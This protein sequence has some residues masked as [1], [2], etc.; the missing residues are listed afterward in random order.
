MKKRKKYRLNIQKSEDMGVFNISVVKNPAIEHDTIKLSKSNDFSLQIEVKLSAENKKHIMFGPILIPNKEILRKTEEGDIDLIFTNEDIEIIR[1]KFAKSNINSN[2]TLEHLGIKLNA[3]LVEHFIQ[4]DMIK[5][6]GFE[7]LK[8][9]WMGGVLI[10]DEDFWNNWV[11]TD[12]VKGFSIEIA[13]VLEEYE[14]SDESDEFEFSK[15]IDELEKYESFF[16]ETYDDYPQA[17]SNN[18]KR[19]LKWAEENGWGSCGTQVGKVRANQLANREPISEDTISRMSAF[20]RHRQNK[21]TPYGEGCGGIMWDSWGGDEGI[22]WAKRKLEQ[23][24]KKD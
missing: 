12:Q 11:E 5:V 14:E 4:T 22:E 15:F 7:E 16:S 21:D 13:G 17:A 10:E 24:R 23:I 6:E 20:A 3:T 8:G 19:A 9:A 18:A 2:I 1:N